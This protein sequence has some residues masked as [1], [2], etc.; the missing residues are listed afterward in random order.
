MNVS[1]GPRWVGFVEEIV[2]QGRYGSA[3]EVVREGPRLVEEREMRLAALRETLNA[4]VAGGGGFSDEELGDAIAAH[5]ATLGP[6]S[7]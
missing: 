4:A 3:S 5:A 1:L 7:S 6:A 2:S